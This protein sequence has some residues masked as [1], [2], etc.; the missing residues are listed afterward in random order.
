M[1]LYRRRHKKV[2]RKRCSRK[3]ARLKA[4]NRRRISRAS[5]GER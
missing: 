4:K 3:N 5:R 2:S 1:Y